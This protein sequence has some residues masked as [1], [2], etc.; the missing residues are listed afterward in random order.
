PGQKASPAPRFMGEDAARLS[1]DHSKVISQ[2]K[3]KLAGLGEV[4]VELGF[5]AYY[6]VFV[7]ETNKNYRKGSWKYLEKALSRTNAIRRI[8]VTRMKGGLG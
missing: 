5:T 2:A 1:A 8:I 6:A 7:H 3:S 4:V